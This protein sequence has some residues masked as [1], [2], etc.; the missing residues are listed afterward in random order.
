MSFQKLPY[1]LLG[2]PP[3]G[4][5]A[6]EFLK[7]ANYA[8]KL[9]I[10]NPQ[11]STEELVA[12]I[13]EAQPTFLLV[14]GFGAILRRAVLDTVA[15]QVLNIHPSLLPEYRGPAPVVQAILDGATE[16]GVTLMEVDTK[17]D[18]GCIL[19]QVPHRLI[20]TELPDELYRVLTQKGVEL[21]LEHIDDYIAEKIDLLPQSEGEATFTHFIKKE[22]GLL[23]LSRPPY[24]LE[25]QIR[26]FQ[27][28][29]RSWIVYQGKRLIIDRAHLESKKLRFDQVQPENGKSMAFSDF[30]VGKRCKPEDIYKEI[31]LL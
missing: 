5:H 2:S 3:I 27:G 21:F 11:L 8:P 24:E 30:C 28:W 26:A 23:D 13:E 18:H 9:V 20:G 10:D 14:V 12:L 1:V 6:L 7:L 17:M 31:G 29:P 25:R 15:G 4:N 19:D 22:D 16:T